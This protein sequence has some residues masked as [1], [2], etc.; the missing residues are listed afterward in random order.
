MAMQLPSR[1]SQ[2]QAVFLLLAWLRLLA[3]SLLLLFVV[4]VSQLPIAHIQHLIN[5]P[6]FSAAY[7]C[8]LLLA[9]AGFALHQRVDHCWHLWLALLAD[10][11]LWFVLVYASG[12]AI[13]PAISYLLVLLAVAALSMPL[14]A[15]AW[16]MLCHGLLYAVLLNIEPNTHHAHMLGWHLWGMWVLFL[17]TAMILLAVVYLLSRSLQQ[18]EQAIARYREDT[19]RNEQLVAMGTL[20][21]TMAH[22]LGSPLSTIAILAAD[23]AGEDGDM[24]RQQ[25]ERCKQ[26]L[27]RLKQADSGLYQPQAIHS[28]ALLSQLQQ[29]ILLLKPACPLQLDDRLDARLQVAPLLRHALLALLTNAADAAASSLQCRLQRDGGQLLVDISHD[30]AAID[31]TLMQSLGRQRVESPGNGLGI[32]YFLAN[33]SIE[34]VGGRLLVSNLAGGGVLTRVM[35]PAERL[36]AND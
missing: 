11:L 35:L 10:T 30:G 4:I 29:E 26:A 9:A 20:A 12:G 14:W 32:G 19:V 21:A 6:V 8:C 1:F 18:K 23:I 15:A 25:V 3:S 16:L 33:A 2:P 13:N 7:G 31:A 28:S 27:A 24:L 36:L 17:M 22:E 34:H 5:W